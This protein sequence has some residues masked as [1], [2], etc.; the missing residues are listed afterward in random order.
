MIDNSKIN[1]F[2]FSNSFLSFQLATR[3]PTSDTSGMMVWTLFKCLGTSHC[4]NSKC[5]DTVRRLLRPVCLQVTNTPPSRPSSDWQCNTSGNYSRLA[6]EIQFVRSMGYYLIQ[7]YIPSSLIVIISWVSFWLN[8]WAQ[9]CFSSTKIY[10]TS[11]WKYLNWPRKYFSSHP[12]KYL[13]C[14]KCLDELGFPLIY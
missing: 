7:I 14:K 6:C 2:I 9:K 8:R 4:H 11:S 3:W 5:S 13:T 10:L 1:F 12:R